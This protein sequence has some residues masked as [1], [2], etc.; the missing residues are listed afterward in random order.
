MAADRFGGQAERPQDDPGELVPVE[1]AGHGPADPLVGERP[2]L[3][4]QRELGEGGFEGLADL[5]A[6]QGRLLVRVLR[7]GL[8][9]LLAG[10]DLLV[11]RL[12]VGAVRDG[13]GAQRLAGREGG[14]GAVGERRPVALALVAGGE[15]DAVGLGGV[16]LGQV[17]PA[18]GERGGAL[19]PRYGAQDQLGELGGAAPP[20][21]VALQPDLAGVL[22]DGVEGEGARGDLQLAAGAVVEGVRGAHDVLR[23]QRREQRLPVGVRLAEGDPHLQVVGTAFDL[24]DAVV[25]GVAGG[26]VRGVLA[27][28]GAPLGGEVGGADLPA[29]APDGLLVE[30]VE[31]DLSGLAVDDLG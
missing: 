19:V 23:V 31:H 3:A 30:L 29:V 16:D 26:P 28:Q 13:P 27:G 22:V 17:D 10:Q 1:G 15:R 14:A 24:L 25:A 7:D 6:A 9:P 11:G 5:E 2:L 12:L 21:R 8:A 4:V 20:A 18:L